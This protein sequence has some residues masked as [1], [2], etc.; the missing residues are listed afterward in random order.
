MPPAQ[1]IT[2][3]G[4]P[5]SH[6]TVRYPAALTKV[7]AELDWNVVD[8][9]VADLV[10]LRA[11]GG[12]LFI[13]GLGGSAGN[14]SHMVNDLRKLAGLEAYAP[15][16]NVSE[17]TARINDDGWGNAFTGWLSV[18][19]LSAEDAIFVLSVG[20]GDLNHGVSPELVYAIDYAKSVGAKVLGI[21]GRNGGH[22]YEFGD[23]VALI[24][25][26][27]DGLTTPLAEAFQAILWHGMVSHPNLAVASAHWES[28]SPK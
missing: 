24:P 19:H 4:G 5:V 16:D 23:T 20:G 3:Q 8:K 27:D 9:L 28:L 15:T 22:T 10:T 25:S 1:E 26:V 12:R 21:V 7:I 17:L 11:T 6:L 14:A 13:L 18:S 2:V